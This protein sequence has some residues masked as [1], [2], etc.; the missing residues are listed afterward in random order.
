MRISTLPWASIL[1]TDN[2]GGIVQSTHISAVS[3]DAGPQ[4]LQTCAADVAAPAPGQVRVRVEAA[5]VSLGDL[6]FQRGVVPGG[7]KPP[8]VPGCDLTGVVESVGAG[9]TT[10]VPGQRVT[11][12]VVSGGYTTVATVG[13]ERLVPVPDGLDATDVAAVALNYFIAYQML[14]RVAAARPGQRLLVHGASGGVGLAF[15]Q[16][17]E[18]VGGL[19]VWGTASAANAD[20]VRRHGAIPIDY[21]AGDFVGTI[22]DAGGD[23]D[24]VFDSIGGLHFRKSYGLLGRGGTLVAY[25]QSDALRNGK[26]SM[27][28]GAIGFLG[29]IVAPKLVPDGRSTVFYNAWSLEKAQPEAYR[30]DLEAVLGL[31]AAGDIAP[32]SVTVVPLADA[33]RALGDIEKGVPGKIVLDCATAAVPSR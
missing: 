9:V 23:L 15:L 2:G 17:A 1:V 31:L 32:R 22:T 8:Y 13:A 10:V 28:T 25:G 14:H 7:P 6:F 21:H 19:T 24:A 20:L 29:G 12:L 18:L 30:E 4:S 33:A 3:R 16:L 11:A 5:G 27:V 26:A